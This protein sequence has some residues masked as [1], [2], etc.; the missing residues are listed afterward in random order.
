MCLLPRLTAALSLALTMCPL[1]RAQDH[2][3]VRVVEVLGFDQVKLE[4][5][6]V[7]R[8]QGIGLPDP[9]VRPPGYEL[10]VTDALRRRA[11]WQWFRVTVEPDP[12]PEAPPPGKVATLA[13]V[14]PG[15][16]TLNEAL[17]AEGLGVLSCR[18]RSVVGL[19]RL[20]AAAA[21]ARHKRLGW[22]ARTP[23][24]TAPLPPPQQRGCVLGLYYQ[25]EKYDYHAQL[26]ELAALGTRWVS[27]L[28]S[29]FVHTVDANEIELH[30][31]RTVTDARLVETIRYA[32]KQGLR[33][34][35]LPIVL[36]R[37]FDPDKDWRGTLRP[38]EP[39]TFWRSYDRFLCHYADL[40][41]AEGVEVLAV[42]S[43]TCSLE[44]PEHTP[45]WRRVIQNARGRFNG[46]LTY[47]ANWD[48]A[49]VPQFWDLLDFAGMTAYFTLTNR[50]DPSLADLAASWPAIK[51]K[52]R[53][54][55]ARIGKPLLITE[56]GYPAIDG[57]NT[58]PWDYVKDSHR[59]DLQE[60]YLATQAFVRAW[61][62][63]QLLLGAYLFDFFGPGGPSDSG[64]SPRGKPVLDVWREWVRA[65][66]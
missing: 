65:P 10:E 18:T 59:L 39:E 16:P 41:Q 32:R 43:E 14:E 7:L 25:E 3:P 45:A 36:I 21:M 57:A 13:P 1:G 52:M 49:E 51:D 24:A 46:W 23:T 33:V 8:L 6:T 60:Q 5:G 54:L 38:T 66:R 27:L 26:D 22:F 28:L 63:D 15:A 19:D 30:N 11:L 2:R 20:T 40:A 31:P 61:R 17:L 4:D 37:D 62:D 12:G 9:T 55:K 58:R 56:I 35:L 50:E 44:K 29:V 42:G 48:H 47:S 64:Y 53:A 34:T